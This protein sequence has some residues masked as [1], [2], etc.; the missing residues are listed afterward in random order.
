V[1]ESCKHDDQQSFPEFHRQQ[2]DCRRHADPG[3]RRFAVRALRIFIPS[4]FAIVEGEA[5]NMSAVKSNK[6]TKRAHARVTPGLP[7]GVAPNAS[8]SFQRSLPKQAIDKR[9]R[10]R[11]INDKPVVS[12]QRHPESAQVREVSQMVV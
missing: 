2:A 10:G 11:M 6:L 1:G 8:H 12:R 5:T 7:V 4:G 9:P 3:R